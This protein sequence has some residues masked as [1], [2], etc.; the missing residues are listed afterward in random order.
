MKTAP[1]HVKRTITVGGN[2]YVHQ[3]AC[4]RA[5]FSILTSLVCAVP[6]E[7]KKLEERVGL[8]PNSAKV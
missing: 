8:T 1:D 4:V 5:S 6:R 7:I 2:T 3:C